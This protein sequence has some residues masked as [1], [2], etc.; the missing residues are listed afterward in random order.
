MTIKK[1]KATFTEGLLAT[2]PND[3]TVHETFIASKR[4]EGAAKDELDA[5]AK[6]LAEVERLE[7]GCTIF[8]RT[9]DGK[10]MIW[11]Y[12]IKGFLKDAVKALRRDPQS[13]SAKVKAF[14]SIIDG[15]VF[16]TP[17]KIVLQLPEGGEIGTC[18][19]PLR[20]Q[21]MM[22]ERVALAQ[23]EEAPAG[24]AIEFEVKTLMPGLDAMLDECWE[25]AKLRFMG[26]WRNSGKGTADIVQL[27]Q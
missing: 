14:K 20:A 3:E 23:S 2:K 17:R 7:K 13:A 10:P 12:Q 18:Q 26:A 15:N 16:I 1:Y 21:T 24:T 9:E 25:Y 6:A 22:G 11:D 8:H 19:R 4:A 27:E 5:E